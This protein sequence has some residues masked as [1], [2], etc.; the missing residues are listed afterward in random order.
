MKGGNVEPVAIIKAGKTTKLG[1]EGAAAA[2]P[3]APAA[4]PAVPGAAPA[5]APAAPM[6]KDAPKK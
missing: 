6:S 4:A 5:A 2:A 3:A 1:T